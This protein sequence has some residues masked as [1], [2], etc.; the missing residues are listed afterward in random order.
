MW[1]VGGCVRTDF[2]LFPL[3]RGHGGHVR[4]GFLTF[5]TLGGCGYCVRTDDF[6][7]FPLRE[8]VVVLKGLSF[9]HFHFGKMWCLK[10]TDLGYLPL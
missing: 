6:E 3:L 8:G 4:T 1:R 2:Q 9:N 7:L 10:R 5:S